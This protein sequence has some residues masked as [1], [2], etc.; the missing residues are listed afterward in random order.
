M[1]IARWIKGTLGAAAVVGVMFTTGLANAQEKVHVALGDVV[2]VETLA[3]LIAMERA[4]DRGVDYELTSFAKEELA[5]QAIINGQAQLGVGTPYSV[6]QKSKVPL[7]AIFQMSRLVFFAVASKEY[8]TWKDL[9]GEPFTFHARGSGT[10]AIG[11]ILAERNGIEFGERSY[12]PGS[13]NRII[14]MINGQIKATI[15]DLANKNL[16][17]EKGGDQFHV[18]PG[19]DEPASDELVFASAEWLENNQE[20]VDIIV[21]ELLRLWR[22]MAENPNVIEEERAKRNLLSDQPQEILD[23]VVPF[24]TEAVKE[25]VFDPSGGSAEAAKADFEF[26]TE[27]GQLE[28]PASDIKVED[29]WDLGPLE[30]AREKLG[31]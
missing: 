4:K 27:A 14:A 5:I 31:G 26:Y 8:A 21:E 1:T 25:G 18:L 30:R 20:Q 2:S 10:E 17:L 29:Y 11:N 12:V 15:V 13:E 24:Y 6:I 3:F 19:I 9:D 16:L 23:E 22:E 28:G 7:K